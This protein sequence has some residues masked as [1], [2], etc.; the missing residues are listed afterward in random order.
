VAPRIRLAAE[1]D[2]DAI[3][4]IYAPIVEETAVSFE[5]AAPTEARLADRIASTLE[6][7]PWLVC[8]TDGNEDEREVVGYAYASSHRDRGAYR[9][10]VD[11]S[12]YVDPDYRRR[13]VARGLYTS[14]FALLE[15]QGFV[16]AYAGIALSNPAS[17]A[18]HESMGFEPVGTYWNVGYKGGE[19]R[20]VQWYGLSLR[21]PPA[22]PEP[23]T[24]LPSARESPK[25]ER[26]LE[27]G[28]SYC[29]L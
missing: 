7:Y 28:E 22:N 26:A 10:S 12:V 18:L 5:D 21:D 11:V 27:S 13:G 17:T 16:S 1:A 9:W 6:R 29:R 24:W 4:R 3:R 2:A 20:D 23:P 19:W 14:L 8:E 25:W 15:L